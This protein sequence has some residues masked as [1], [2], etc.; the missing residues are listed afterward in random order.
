ML[1]EKIHEIG[2]RYMLIV[3]ALTGGA[4]SWAE[5]HWGDVVTTIIL[6]IVGTLAS[7]ATKVI[8][9]KIVIKAKKRRRRKHAQT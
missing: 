6:A 2:M 7:A 9:D 3:G 5:N 1:A 4:V 8:S